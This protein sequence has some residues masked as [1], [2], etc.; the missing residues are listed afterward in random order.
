MSTSQ[1][2]RLEA[3]DALRGLIMV[4]MA[5]DHAALFVAGQHYAEFWGTPLP[6]YPHAFGL[7]T[8][9]I[10]H[11]CAPG[12]FFLMGVGM[13][14]FWASRRE[15]GWSEGEIARHFAVRGGVLVLVDLFII[16]PAFILGMWEQFASGE[17]L[18]DVIPG[19]SGEPMLVVNVL[20]TL[21]LSMIVSALLMRLGTKATAFLALA[22]LLACQALLPDASEAFRTES[23]LSR[24][25]LVAG[26]DGFLVVN[27][28]LL[29]WLSVC[30]FGVAYGGALRANAATGLKAALPAGV[31][32][33]LLFLVVRIAGGFGAH[34]PM[35]DESWMALLE[36]TKYPP[37]IAFLLLGL[38]GNA[39][40]LSIILGMQKHLE[41][42]GRA[43]LVFGRSALFFYVLHMYI[44]AIFGRLY[45]GE[46]SLLGMYPA[47][48]VGLVILYPLCK[49]YDEF[50]RGTGEASIWRLF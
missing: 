49:K 25:L 16:T 10:S 19:I 36:V 50:K 4:V 35:S 31:A 37:S 13:H 24:L 7:F 30:L 6:V 1:G 3:L 14:F 40:F 33:L 12:F 26:Q 18:A 27:Y 29:P 47:W 8:R 46:T 42:P 43:L 28:P 5:I 20:A 32:M 34:H 11:L 41:G 44:Y 38:G 23:F 17:G 2:Q 48:F 45:P 22:I 21:G 39:L 15:R 9:V